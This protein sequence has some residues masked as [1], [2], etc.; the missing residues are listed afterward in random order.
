MQYLEFA[1]NYWNVSWVPAFTYH[2]DAE[3]LLWL[4]TIFCATYSIT[5]TFAMTGGKEM[6]L[7]SN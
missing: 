3:A 1:Y 6:P 5:S 2:K 7:W 4:P